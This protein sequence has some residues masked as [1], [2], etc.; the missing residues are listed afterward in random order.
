MSPV[1]Q[2]L[3]L[4][5]TLTQQNRLRNAAQPS[6][7]RWWN[8]SFSRKR[9]SGG[10]VS[11]HDNKTCN[12]ASDEKA[13]KGVLK[14]ARGRKLVCRWPTSLFSFL[15]RFLHPPPSLL[16]RPLPSPSLFPSSTPF[17][18]AAPARRYT[19]TTVVRV[20][21]RVSVCARARKREEMGMCGVSAND[22]APRRRSHTV[23]QPYPWD[24]HTI[25]FAGNASV[26]KYGRRAGD[27]QFQISL[28]KSALARARTRCL[29]LIN[30]RGERKKN[31]EN[32]IGT[33]DASSIR[34]EWK[35][36][37]YEIQYFNWRLF[38]VMS[39]RGTI[40]FTPQDLNFFVLFQ[41]VEG[42]AEHCYWQK[43]C[44]CA[45]EKSLHFIYQCRE[46]SSDY[47]MG[48]LC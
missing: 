24:V 13:G 16:S 47:I 23:A 46:M 35:K 15:I 3:T 27:A 20:C 11:C 2:R 4:G 45:V 8:A 6:A 43:L 31:T 17:I 41:H 28:S 38:F 26:I 40:C 14:K 39:Q 29:H 36:N 22:T 48:W 12:V 42:T 32:K 25:S 44:N 7:C 37:N 18:R 19:N 34:S 10:G 5:F 21:A 1:R 30:L 9:V 33:E